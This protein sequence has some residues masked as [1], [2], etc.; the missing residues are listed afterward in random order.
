[1]TDKEEY[2][3]TPWDVEGNVNY[4][5]LIEKFGT[6]RID[7]EIREKIIEAA[8]EDHLYLRRDF[9]Y[10]HRDMDKI[11][12]DYEE[13]EDFF[14]YTGIGPSGKMHIGHVISFYF[15]K[16]L[17]KAFDVNVYIQVTDDEKHW[18][19]DMSFEE[20]DKNAK[21]NI[22][23]IAA[24]GFDPDKTFI[25]RNR[26][27]MGN[28]YDGVVKVAGKINN[29]TASAVFGFE[30][31]TNIGMNF[32]PAIQCMPTFFENKRCLIPAA[33]DQDPYWRI[34][35]DIAEKLGYYKTAAIHSK[36]IPA[37][38][39]PDGKMSSSKPKTAIMLDDSP[40]EI[41]KKVKQNAFSGGGTTLEE[42]REKGADLSVDVSYQWLHNL[43][44]EDDEQLEK[45]AR[46]YSSGE[47]LTGEIKE[48]LIEELQEFIGA[49]QERKENADELV[50]QMMYD[51]DLA[52]EMWDKKIDL[53]PGK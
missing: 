11:L 36:F 49:H 26:E 34:Q 20:I 33:I 44:L 18:D 37:L 3:V 8:G 51:G 24:V 21:Q 48:I 15:T 39:G 6:E 22:R 12:E 2:E 47:M 30:G 50:Q 16:W 41:E 17:Q 45:I 28:M 5:E 13:G 10:S 27:Y 53:E 25:F 19:R 38:T 31:S 7:D 35:R 4:N 14:L 32:W 46:E 9:I 43:L 52:Q 42:H 29:S 1:M 40:E 23:E